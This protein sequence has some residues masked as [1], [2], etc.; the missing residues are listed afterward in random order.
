[1]CRA[2]HSLGFTLVELLVV[3]S[4]V[5]ALATIVWK[6][7]AGLATRNALQTQQ[8]AFDVL[9]DAVAAYLEVYADYPSQHETLQVVMDAFKDEILLRDRIA[10]DSEVLYD[11]LDSLKE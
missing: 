11:I 10:G 7:N 2:K 3:I 4:I 8:R 9:G 5:I 6:A 1:M